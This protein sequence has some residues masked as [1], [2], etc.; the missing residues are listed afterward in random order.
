MPFGTLIE[1]EYED[2]FI[3]KEDE[4]DEYYC[5]HCN[6]LR[7]IFHAV[8]HEQPVSE[9]GQMVRWSLRTSKNLYSIDWKE[10]LTDS[11]MINPRPVRSFDMEAE[12]D[13]VT[14]ELVGEPR[15]VLHIFGFQYN[16]PDGSNVK[17]IQEI[18]M[19]KV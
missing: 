14:K 16:N 3:L 10:V 11:S 9:H 18:E 15:A 7:N 17:D 19:D 13:L 12:F 4:K 8:L 6:K 5:L 2:G 1:A